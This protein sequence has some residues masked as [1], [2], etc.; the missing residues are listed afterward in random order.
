M[1]AVPAQ[2]RLEFETLIADTSASFITASPDDID[3]VVNAALERL[4]VF[5]DVDRVG[6]LHVA[7]DRVVVRLRQTACGP[8][9]PRVPPTIELDRLCPWTNRRALIEQQPVVMRRLDDLPPKRPRTAPRT[10]T[11]G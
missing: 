6:L 4:R 5:L 2:A 9:V 10:G 7:V 3:A 8:G 11:W 1:A